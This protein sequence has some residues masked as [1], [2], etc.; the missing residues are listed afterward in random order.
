VVS[1]SL[2]AEFHHL[3]GVLSKKEDVV[4]II[5]RAEKNFSE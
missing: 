3:S 1:N 4:K 2:D 5:S